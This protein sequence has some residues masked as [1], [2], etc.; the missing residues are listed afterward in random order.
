[1]KSTGITELSLHHF[2]LMPEAAARVELMAP[3]WKH[4]QDIPGQLNGRLVASHPVVSLDVLQ[5][6]RL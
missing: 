3:K 2:A 1:M 4:I 5:Y 6:T